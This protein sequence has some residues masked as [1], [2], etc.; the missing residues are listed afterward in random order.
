VR[1]R[2]QIL[3]IRLEVSFTG[4][5]FLYTY[6]CY[7]IHRR[8]SQVYTQETEDAG[9]LCAERLWSR[10]L[11]RGVSYCRKRRICEKENESLHSMLRCATEQ[12]NVSPIGTTSSNSVRPLPALGTPRDTMLRTTVNLTSPS[13][14]PLPTTTLAVVVTMTG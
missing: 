10:S 14:P 9:V 6:V 8:Q 2:H 4:E 5:W 1:R 11:M 3:N 12:P 7:D 13:R